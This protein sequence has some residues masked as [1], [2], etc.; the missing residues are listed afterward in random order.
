MHRSA[1]APT[2]RASGLTDLRSSAIAGEQ[3]LAWFAAEGR[4]LPWRLSR[5]PW[6]ILVSELMLQ[7]TQVARV[8][9]RWPRFLDRFPTA[10]ACA[11]GPVGAVIDEWS[12]LGYN[13]RAVNLHRSAVQIRDHH[14][15]DVPMVLDE[16]LSLPGIGAYTAR[17]VLAF[18]GERD[19]GVVDTNIGRVLARLGGSRLARAEA[20]Q[21]ADELV[22]TGRGWA[23]NQALMELGALVCRPTPTCN[24]CPIAGECRWRGIG[25]DPARGSAAVSRGQSTFAGSDRQGRGRLVA[26]LRSGPVA[27]EDLAA[28]MGWPDDPDRASRVASGVVTDGLAV[29]GGSGIQ[30]P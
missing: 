27:T 12:G 4:E 6:G 5:D 10:A 21:L 11:D 20:Q 24:T 13:R 30:L 9:D 28:V 7:Q 15:G 17:A 29:L 19:V 22:P 2:T 25:P 3:L 14:G 16:L 1:S 26:A 23:W 8:V 18:A